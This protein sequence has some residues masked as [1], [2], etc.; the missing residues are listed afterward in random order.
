MKSILLIL[1]FYF[2]VFGSSG[3]KLNILQN[4]PTD[5]KVD[6]LFKNSFMALQNTIDNKTHLSKNES[7]FI[8]LIHY[9]SGISIEIES[10]SGVPKFKMNNL[11][12][13]EKW[14]GIHK[15]KIKWKKVKKGLYILNSNDINESKT[16]ELLKLR[17]PH[18]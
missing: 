10:Y 8:Y 15:G 13:L 14:Y 1:F 2:V 5:R 9:L 7:S 17:I 12:Q 18:I 16:K 3:S 11:L 4:S 6:S